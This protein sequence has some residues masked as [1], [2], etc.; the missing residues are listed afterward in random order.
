VVLPA[1]SHNT[2][3]YLEHGMRISASVGAI[4]QPIHCGW[5]DIRSGKICNIGERRCDA[6]QGW[7]SIFKRC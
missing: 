3:E 2:P 4:D 1:N 7:W 5:V 6:V